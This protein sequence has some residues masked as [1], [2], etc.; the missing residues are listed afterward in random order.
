MS[1]Q[2]KHLLA[3]GFIVCLLSVILCLSWIS[4]SSFDSLYRG[5]TSILGVADFTFFVFLADRLEVGHTFLYGLLTFL[6]LFSCRIHYAVVFPLIIGVTAGFS[7]N[8]IGN[9]K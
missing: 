4:A 8:Q 3:A 1:E 9:V 6:L 5:V 2:Q 7:S